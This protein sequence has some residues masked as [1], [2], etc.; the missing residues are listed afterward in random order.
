MNDARRGFAPLPIFYAARNIGRSPLRLALTAGGGALVVF[1]VVGSMA[2]VRALDR[3][4]R[5][6]GTPGNV[7]LVGAGSEESVERSEIPASAPGVLAASIEGIRHEGG[8]QFI[9]P[10]LHVPLPLRREGDPAPEGNSRSLALVRGVEPAAFLVHPQARLAAGRLADAGADE[11]VVGR[12]LAARLRIGDA[13]VASS[14]EALPVVLIDERPHRVTGIIDA[15]GVAIDGEAWMPISDLL[16]L[17]KRQTISAAVV[18]L[19][20]ADIGDL[21]AFA[22]RR[23]DLEIAA[24]DEPAYYAQLAQ[25]FRP[26][27]ILIGVS[28]LIVALGAMLG[29]LNALDA[30]FASRSREIAM[31]QVLGFSRGAVILSLVQESVLAVAT[32]AL[33]ALLIARL[34]LDGVGVRFSMGVFSLSVDAT[35]V[36]SGLGAGL[37]LGVVGSLPPAIRCMRTAIPIALKADLT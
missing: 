4:V 7:M 17:T 9:S 5:A 16:V 32:G 19:D 1:L 2:S 37:L 35:C 28:A 36:A 29:G 20:G 31:L 33:P 13:D 34:A 11:I 24:I 15:P 10:E 3:G 21:E 14:N 8:A 6:S 22:A 18:S 23:S 12:A 25:F 26:V 27:Q 30:A